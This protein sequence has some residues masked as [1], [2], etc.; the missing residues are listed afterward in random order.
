MRRHGATLQWKCSTVAAAEKR[1][2]PGGAERAIARK[3]MVVLPCGTSGGTSVVHEVQC[4]TDRI[5]RQVAGDDGIVAEGRTPAIVGEESAERLPHRDLFIGVAGGLCLPVDVDSTL[6]TEAEE[7]PLREGPSN[8]DL[9]VRP[10]LLLYGAV[11]WR[12]VGSQDVSSTT[13][14]WPG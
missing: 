4:G 2:P 6:A 13:S 9:E 1:K 3:H 7:V 11:P 10:T 8:V 5:I 14:R 12:Y